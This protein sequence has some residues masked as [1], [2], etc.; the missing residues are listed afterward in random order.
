MQF[1]SFPVAAEGGG[2]P[3][4]QLTVKDTNPVWIHCEQTGHC[5]KGESVH[6]DGFSVYRLTLFAGMVFAVNPPPEGSANSFS[7]FQALALASGSATAT[8][9]SG[10][11]YTTPPPPTVVTITATI[12]LGSTT[13]T[14]TYGSYEGT[15]RKLCFACPT[16]GDNSA[17]SY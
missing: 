4:F 13:Y 1:F 3:S 16:E 15:P 12:T 6:Y 2:L 17:I 7:A 14:T 5:G 9:A 8:A 11:G 10:T